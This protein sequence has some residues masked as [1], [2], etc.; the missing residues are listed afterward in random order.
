MAD[1]DN[2]GG[3]KRPPAHS[4]FTKGQSGNP[5]GRPKKVPNFL[6]DAAFILNAPV[7][8]HASG[9]PVTLPALQAMFRRMCQKALKGD[10]AALRRVIDLMLTLEPAAQQQAEQ[11]ANAHSGAKRKLIQMLGGDPDAFEARPKKPNPEMDKLR[12]QADAMAKEERKRLIRE[13]KRRKQNL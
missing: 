9:K 3:Y 4:R 12:K 10:N 13:A 8:G 7:T 5:R 2:P 1:N 11:N 6:E